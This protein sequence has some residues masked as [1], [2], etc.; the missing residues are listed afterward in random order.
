MNQVPLQSNTVDCACFAI[1]FAKKFLQN[2][3]SAF[4][5]IKVNPQ[6][7]LMTPGLTSSFRNGFPLPPKGWQLGGWKIPT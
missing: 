3:D 6:F 2:P 5:L 4:A 7:P 1:Y